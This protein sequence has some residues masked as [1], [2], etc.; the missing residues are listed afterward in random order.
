M[1]LTRNSITDCVVSMAVAAT[2]TIPAADYLTV[3]TPGDFDNR[4]MLYRDRLLDR[5]MDVSKML[6]VTGLDAGSFIRCRDA[7]AHELAIL[8]AR[9]DLVRRFDTPMRRAL[10]LKM[11]AYFAK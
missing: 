8:S 7:I 6:R 10:D 11:D 4:Q 3:A 9:P 5:R 1:R 2:V